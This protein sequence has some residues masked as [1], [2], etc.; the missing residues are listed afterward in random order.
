MWKSIVPGTELD[1][2]KEDRRNSVRIE[3]YRVSENAVYFNGQYLPLSC[4]RDVS[5]LESSFTP[6]MSCGK[7]I[8]VFKIRIDYGAGK[9]LVLMV[10]KKKN[11]D[12]MMDLIAGNSGTQHISEMESILDEAIRRMD[13]L[14]KSIGEFEAYQDE[15][16]KLEAYYTSD[17]WKED[18]AAD[19]AGEY[20][21]ELKR[22]VLSEDGIYNMLERNKELRKKTG[23]N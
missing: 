9:P 14:E 11:V 17:R 8:P 4:I 7:G 19:E 20:P 12:A 2:E 15:I 3:Q 1:N 21:E 18:L 10:E 13:A 6:G 22:G 5:V 23:S 16:D